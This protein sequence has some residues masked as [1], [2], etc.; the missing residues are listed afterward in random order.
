MILSLFFKSSRLQ[1]SPPLKPNLIPMDQ[2]R[3]KSHLSGIGADQDGES[4]MTSHTFSFNILPRPG[5]WTVTSTIII[6]FSLDF[7]SMLQSAIMCSTSLSQECSLNRR[8]I[9]LLKVHESCRFAE[10]VPRLFERSF[11]SLC[12]NKHMKN[13]AQP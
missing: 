11:C 6:T 9:G 5:Q 12:T 13:V 1:A 10:R 8:E 2:Y 4:D 7:R 3:I